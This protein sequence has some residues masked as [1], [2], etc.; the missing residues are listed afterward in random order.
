MAKSQFEFQRN[1]EGRLEVLKDGRKVGMI[2]TMGDDLLD[3]D[4]PPIPP[5]YATLEA[6]VEPSSN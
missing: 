3:V 4:T 1:E 6:K 2:Y 5:E